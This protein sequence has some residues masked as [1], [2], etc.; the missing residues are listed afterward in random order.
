MAP[1]LYVIAGLILGGIV[2]WASGESPF[3][4]GDS[5]SGRQKQRRGSGHNGI[6]AADST[7]RA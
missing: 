4:A 1:A 7:E 3:R 2:G 6:E 5:L